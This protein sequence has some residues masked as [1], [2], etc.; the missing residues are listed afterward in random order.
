MKVRVIA[1]S[2]IH[3][4]EAKIYELVR[5]HRGELVDSREDLLISAGGDGT[6]LGALRA[7]RPEALILPLRQNSSGGNEDEWEALIARA[8]RPSSTPRLINIQSLQ[9]RVNN[10]VLLTAFNEITIGAQNRREA[11]RFSL[12]INS[13]TKQQVIGDGVTIATSFGSTGKFKSVTGFSFDVKGIGIG[14]IAPITPVKNKVTS[15]WNSIRLECE[16]S[17]GIIWADN[18]PNIISFEQPIEIRNGPDK[19]IIGL[20]EFVTINGVRRWEGE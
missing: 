8:M 11:L 6:F 20:K 17:N 13:G 14:Y 19:S 2:D 15:L 1:S 10:Q 9:V 5:R 18:N 12:S 16:R 7:S 4:H 3:D